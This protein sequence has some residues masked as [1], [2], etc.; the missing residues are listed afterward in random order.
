MSRSPA[1]VLQKAV[2]DTLTASAA[3]RAV[4]GNPARVYDRPP[5]AVSFPYVDLG[6]MQ[7]LEDGAACIDGSEVIMTLHVW[8]RA[9]GQVD[10]KRG[11]DALR[12][13]LDATA[14]GMT[15]HAAVSVAFEDA[16][17]LVDPDGITTHAVVTFRALTEAI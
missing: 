4:F 10:A 14:P 1:L 12:Q 3:V 13:A 7:E 17:Y 11:V 2:L 15:G 6:E 16:R 9:V 5:A 8:S